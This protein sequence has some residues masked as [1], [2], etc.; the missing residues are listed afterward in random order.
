[1]L[2]E[3]WQHNRSKIEQSGRLARAKA[4]AA[5][6]AVYYTDPTL[7]DG[8]I[9]EMPDG[10]RHLIEIIDGIDVVKAALPSRSLRREPAE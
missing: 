9:R 6:I 2:I 5:G 4:Q 8:I 7:A 1:M 3:K 10:E